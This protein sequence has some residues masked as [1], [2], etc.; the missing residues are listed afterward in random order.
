MRLV[1]AALALAL[2]FGAQAQQFPTKRVTFVSGVTPGSASDTMARILADKLQQK[3]GQTVIVENKLGAGGLVGAKYVAGTEPDGTTIM[4]YASAYTVSPL[5]QPSVMKIDELQPT[6]T[7]ATIPTVLVVQPEKYKTLKD[8][9]SAAKAKPGKLVCTDAGIGSA[10]HMAFERF[11]FAAGI[12]E[13]INVHTKGV[14][15]ALTEVIAGRADCYF[16][17]VFQ[18]KKI[19][20]SGKL[21]A[22]ATSS[23]KRSA[24]MP[25]T[26]TLEEQGLRNASYNFWVG[27]LVPAKT[28]RAIVDKIHDDITALVES[29]DVTAQIKK[30]GC[31]PL[32]MSVKGFEDMVATEVRENTEIIKKANIKAE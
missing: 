21:I 28:P 7:V 1:L 32:P 17:L 31:D 5:L 13:V 9:V 19:V 3:W 14:G 15:E 2:S 23:P 25:E 12:P 26:P 6:A 30:L 4:M 24:L 8:F 29:P 27:A 22:L 16:A 10:T 18:A 20:D 11:R